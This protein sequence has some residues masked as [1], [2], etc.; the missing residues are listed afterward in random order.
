MHSEYESLGVIDSMVEDL[1]LRL[2]QG[3][4]YAN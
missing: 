2:V 1:I 3:D 4:K